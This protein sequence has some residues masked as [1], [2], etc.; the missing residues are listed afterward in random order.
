MNV[1]ADE[2]QPILMEKKRL[3]NGDHGVEKR[4]AVNA[5]QE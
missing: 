3:T 5:L 2:I 4:E 1:E